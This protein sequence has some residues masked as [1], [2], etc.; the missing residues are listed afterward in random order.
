[1][2]FRPVLNEF[3]RTA[4]QHAGLLEMFEIT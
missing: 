4:F 1:V 2:R 3:V